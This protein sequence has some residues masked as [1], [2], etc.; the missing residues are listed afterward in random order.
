MHSSPLRRCASSTRPSASCCST[1]SALRAR[2]PRKRRLVCRR[3]SSAGALLS[4]SLEEPLEEQATLTA[5][6]SVIVPDIADICRID[7]LDKDGVLQ[8]KLT[9]H[10]DPAREAAL[11]EFV[12]DHASLPTPGSFAWALATGKTFLANF[13]P[14]QLDSYPAQDLGAFAR[15]FNVRAVCVV[16]LVTRGRTIGAM[17]ALQAESGRPLQRGGRCARRR[18]RAA[19]SARARQRPP[20]P[21]DAR[22]VA[23]SGGREPRQGR[24]RGDG[25]PRAAQPARADRHLARRHGASRGT[26]S[27]NASAA[28]SSAKSRTSRAWSTTCSTSRASRRERSGC[29]AGASTCAT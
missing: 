1:P 25:R 18:A 4:R 13:E 24:I 29:A 23:R 21:R 2:T 6:G 17:C 15:D 10:V 9:H 3:S 8:P 14:S 20:V 22:C 5:I 26:R 28:S 19:R 12:R 7:L 16:P 27:T 11:R